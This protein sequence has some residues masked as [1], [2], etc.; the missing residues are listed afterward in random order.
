MT[1]HMGCKLL[2]R[3]T[4]V[5]NPYEAGGQAAQIASRNGYPRP[6]VDHKFARERCLARYKAG[7][8]RATA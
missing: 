1:G 2:T 7:I 5:H 6:I 8:G 4:D 3:N